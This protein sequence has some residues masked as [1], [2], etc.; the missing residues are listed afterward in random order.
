M[1]KNSGG[2][3]PAP[4][5]APATP[6]PGPGPINIK[7]P[8]PEMV[9]SKT[10]EQVKT[11]T[12]T[13]IKESIAEAAAEEGEEA[14]PGDGAPAPVDDDPD[15]SATKDDDDKPDADEDDESDG[16]RS[17]RRALKK[18]EKAIQKK[19]QTVGARETQLEKDAQMLDQMFGKSLLARR[20]VKSGDGESARAAVEA[21]LMDAT[22]M[23]LDDAMVYLV[24]PS[25][26]KTPEQREIDKLKRERDQEKREREEHGLKLQRQAEEAKAVDWIKAELAGQPLAKLPGFERMVLQTMI[27]RYNDGAK[28]PKKAAKMVIEGLKQTYD[29]LLG[30]FGGAAPPTA[31]EPEQRSRTGRGSPPREGAAGRASQ[32]ART[33]TT[34]DIIADVMLEENLWKPSDR[35]VAGLRGKRV[36]AA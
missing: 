29:Q 20:A 27:Q 17:T 15:A 34:G 6:A 4:A 14:T 24:D 12:D 28:T 16:K 21:L 18:R 31:P 35:R 9:G 11:E 22:G 23:T 1:A 8:G 32:D 25:K 7:A 10:R 2:A 19:E 26:A 30:V 5:A 13:A 33:P 36:G 3:A